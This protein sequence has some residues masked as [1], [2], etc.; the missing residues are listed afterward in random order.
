MKSDLLKFGRPAECG[1]QAV[2]RP[3][4]RLAS[5]R[6]SSLEKIQQY[7]E[8]PVCTGCKYSL[9]GIWDKP[10][11]T[12]P[13]CGRACG[14]ADLIAQ[15]G[16]MPAANEP[17]LLKAWLGVAMV[18]TGFCLVAMGGAIWLW[19]DR[20]GWRWIDERPWILWSPVIGLSL[21]S[22]MGWLGS[23]IAAYSWFR[24]LRGVWLWL[25]AQW[26]FAV[27]MVSTVVLVAWALLGIL[28]AGFWFEGDPK[29]PVFHLPGGDW[30]WSDTATH[31]CAFACVFALLVCV[32]IGRRVIGRAC[33]A[34]TIRRVEE[35]LSKR[36]QARES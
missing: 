32:M 28:T 36:D 2:P 18:G 26:I 27:A 3:D 11:A 4:A 25:V 9:R 15:I 24:G 35:M 34:E 14:R 29:S 13:E 10:R 31:G 12:C 22:V 6:F 7:F 16:R 1:T 5:E 33:R 23:A 20:R 21:L 30:G 17:S 19:L 8:E